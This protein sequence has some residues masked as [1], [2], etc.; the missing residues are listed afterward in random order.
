[1]S[2]RARRVGGA[3]SLLGLLALVSTGLATAGNGQPIGPVQPT[4]APKPAATD[5][6]RKVAEGLLTRK[7][8]RPRKLKTLTA[9]VKGQLSNQATEAAVADVI[10]RLAKAG[11][12]T[13][14]EG[15]LTW[16]ST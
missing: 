16:P 9:F 2:K 10:A 13:G 6:I 4:P 5:R 15:N 11:M 7:E 8:A 12:S 3:L 1:M 14:A